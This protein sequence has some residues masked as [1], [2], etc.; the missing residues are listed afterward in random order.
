MW[1][2]IIKE[3]LRSSNFICHEVWTVS[4]LT[5]GLSVL[6]PCQKAFW[7]SRAFCFSIK[8]CFTKC[9]ADATANVMR[10]TYEKNRR[11]FETRG[12]PGACSK[13]GMIWS[14]QPLMVSFFQKYVLKSRFTSRL[15]Q[16]LAF[17]CPAQEKSFG[18]ASCGWY[19]KKT[20]VR[21]FTERRSKYICRSSS[22]KVF[23]DLK[24]YLF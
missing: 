13:L 20:P 12:L 14:C 7:F 3:K 4:N 6:Y 24:L 16:I 5:V 17:H 21:Y 22:E 2:V 1:G 15:E 18:D 23:K 11:L 9:T 10:G 8:T 19:T